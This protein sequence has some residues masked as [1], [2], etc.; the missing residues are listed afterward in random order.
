MININ[1][2]NYGYNLPE[3][4]LPDYYN[5]QLGG[6]L[7]SFQ[8]IGKQIYGNPKDKLQST[9]GSVA[10]AGLNFIPGV[11]PILSQLGVGSAL[12]NIGYELFGDKR[13]P[14]QQLAPS[15]TTTGT[16]QDYAQEGKYITTLKDNIYAFKPNMDPQTADEIARANLKY[17]ME[18]GHHPQDLLAQQMQESGLNP[19]ARSHAGA[20]GLSQFMPRTARHYG[21]DVNDID[22]SVQGQA[23]YMNKLERRF[24]TLE[25]ARRGYNMGGSNYKRYM[26]NNKPLPRE[27]EEYPHKIAAMHQR[28][29]KN[30][31][32]DINYTA[33]SDVT[34]AVR[35][36]RGYE[37]PMMQ[38]DSTKVSIPST[39]VNQPIFFQQGGNVN[40]KYAYQEWVKTLPHNLRKETKDYNLF[41]AWKGG[42][43][44]E[45]VNGEWHL[46]SRNPKNGNLLKS[47][48]HPT[49]NKM[50]E[51][52]IK[53]G[54]TPSIK[55]NNGFL[56]SFQQGGQQLPHEMIHDPNA[57]QAEIEGE[58]F[59]YNRQGIDD[60]TFKMLDNKGVD[61][62]SEYG[63][64]AKGNP[65]TKGGISISQGDAYIASKY[66]GV[67]GKKSGKKNPSVAAEILKA[68]G[69]QLGKGYER[70]SDKFGINSY[71]KQAV[72]H[73]LDMMDDIKA[74]AEEGK[75]IQK[76]KEIANNKK[77]KGEEK[78]AMLSQILSQLS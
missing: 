59:V 44:P 3:A 58:E 47:P 67:N 71:N 34:P 57:K 16:W 33:Q 8:G 23:K 5:Y 22:S 62:K 40:E 63:L 76:L 36:L 32:P 1:D 29:I 78:E 72:K 73:H 48:N 74:S 20:Q 41:E 35:T 37:E 4:I 24:D 49:Y 65:H 27:A 75:M 26:R 45:F 14:A 42:L 77:L 2:Y 12:T 25:D 43:S 11:G 13:Q 19:N 56:F 17:S 38:R 70:K 10:D 50:I 51:G 55:L 64:L 52:E 60:T 53:A 46:G 69:N 31:L 7:D 9:I 66:L 61:K 6:L 68:G 30:R 18:Y 54:Y 39:Q 15:G 28:Y 21:V